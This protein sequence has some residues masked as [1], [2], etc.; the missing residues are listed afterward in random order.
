[1]KTRLLGC[2]IAL[3]AVALAPASAQAGQVKAG[4]AVLDGTYHVGNSAGQYASTRDEGYGDVDPHAQQVKNQASYGVQSRETVRALVIKGP[5]GKYVAMLSDNHYIPQDVL[6]R[7][8]VQLAEEQTGG[9]IN[10]TNLTMTSTHNHSSP[11]YSSINWGVW[12]FQDVFDFRFFD[13]YARQNAAAIKKAF[14]NLHDV[15]VSATAS[16]FDSFQRNPMGPEFQDGEPVGFPRPYTDH[17]LSV[18][19]FQNIDDRKSPKPLATL[20]NLGQHPEFLDGYDLISGEFPATMERFVDREA[21]GVTIFTQNA[22]GTSEVE[23]DNWHPVHERQLF[24]HAQY[25]QMEWGARQLADAVLANLRDIRRQKP[26]HDDRPTQ[27][28]GTSYRDRFVKWMSDFP[29]GIDDRWFPGPVSHPYPGV[30]SC[31]L[32]PTLGGDPRLNGVPECVDAPIGSSLMPITP[33]GG[34]TPGISTDTFQELGIPVPETVSTPSHTGL[35]DTLGV[36]M[37]AIRLG[38]ILLTVCSCE[39]W[40][41]QSWNIKTRTDTR[42]GNEYLGYDPTSEDAH[43]SLRCTP[44]GDGTY[45]ADGTGTGRWTCAANGDRRKLTDRRVQRIRA[46]V[47]NDAAGWDDPACTRMGCGYQAEAE[48]TRLDQIF[49]NFTHDDTTVRGGSNQTKDFAG[50]YGYKL[51]VTVSMANDYNGYIASYNEFMN[52]DHYRKSLTGWGPHSS[53]Y[54]ATRLSQMGRALKG[55]ED[56]RTTIDGQTDPAKA[57]PKWAHM[58]AKE[59][60]DQA[61]EDAK[62]RAVGEAATT[63]TK[64]YELTLPDDGGVDAE[65]VQPKDIERFDSTTFTWDGGNNYTDDPVVT[66]ERMED[67]RWVTFADQTGEVP[68]TVKYPASNRSHPPDP[69]ALGNGLVGY[70]A[71]GQ[72]W[73]WTAT[74]EAFVSQFPLV[75]PQGRTYWAT[76]TG[77]YRFVVH[78]KWRKGRADAEYTRVS[79]PFQVKPWT[80]ITAEG[81]VAPTG[82]LV[83]DPGPTRTVQEK[84]VRR[85]DRPPLVPGNAPVTFTIGPI[86]YPDTAKDQAATGARFLNSLRGYSAASREEVEHYCL[87]CSF[88]PWLDAGGDVVA[89]VT[90]QRAGGGS[91]TERVR[92][93]NGVFRTKN[94][95]RAGDSASVQIVD[96][97]GNSMQQPLVVTA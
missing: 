43:P 67:G 3:L 72:T 66:V 50:R 41:E 77:T 81:S 39:Q 93:E 83:V 33:L 2:S 27:Y 91:D 80:G 89:V 21:G 56:S 17:D 47:L 30:A 55:H 46:R 75:D 16:H 64:A 11:S 76:P 70:R 86:D 49:G 44:D 63:A 10:K 68:V 54:Y 61:Q 9:A 15:R 29:V 19:H 88:R 74:F 92:L 40:V 57:D 95:M 36:H 69:E 79:N 14:D 96:A 35:E 20:V 22:T 26:N 42:P 60:A 58:V 34:M 85:T 90:I 45:K 73:K 71:G 84:T 87:D 48:P 53:D 82:Q 51:V 8:T 62:V 24:D 13:Y 1:M 38:D 28:G 94:R 52:H 7:R 18:V 65:L 32:D 25:Q 5:D 12:T 97:W 37:Q 23:K 78:G 31:R 4:V 59:V 6:W